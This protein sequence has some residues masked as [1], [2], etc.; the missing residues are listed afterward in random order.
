MF[1]K[2]LFNGHEGKIGE[3]FVIYRIELIL[4]H[5]SQQVGELHGRYVKNAAQILTPEQ[6]RRYDASLGQQRL[7]LDG[8]LKFSHGMFNRGESQAK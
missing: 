4:L 7:E 8:F 5:E 2:Y 6:L 1:G 3:M